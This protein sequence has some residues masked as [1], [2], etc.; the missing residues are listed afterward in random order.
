MFLDIIILKCVNGF[1][2]GRHKSESKRRKTGYHTTQYH[3]T[4]NNITFLS[5]NLLSL[6]KTF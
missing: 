1:V 3:C 4:F 5:Y 2:P 6:F